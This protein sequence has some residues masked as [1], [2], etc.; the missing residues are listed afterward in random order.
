MR[1]N[2]IRVALV[3]LCALATE[4]LNAQTCH[5]TARAGGIALEHGALSIG[6]SEGASLAFAGNRAAVGA[7]YRYRNV[8]SDLT[9]HEGAMR[10]SLLFGG[11]RLLVCPTVGLDYQRDRWSV[12]ESQSV[13][14]NRVAGRGGLNAA[15]D[16]VIGESLRISPFAGA[17]YEFAII[18]FES[19]GGAGE[20]N[21][22]GDTLSH[23]E[24]EYGLV[25][26]YR[27]VFAGMIADRYSDL[28]RPHLA[29]L[30][31]GL[32]FGGPGSKPKSAGAGS[33]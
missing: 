21:V 19:D 30:V 18:D 29:R 24:I 2:R 13:V 31:L 6:T 27:A 26:R 11:S 23:V 7:A 5:G 10:F 20:A 8:Q 33:R 3:V 15:Y 28:K 12:N 1:R 22:T 16:F 25:A 9:G 17:Q 32:A 4:Q 14:S